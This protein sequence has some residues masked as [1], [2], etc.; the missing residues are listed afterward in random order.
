MMT[1]LNDIRT[2]ADAHSN[3]LHFVVPPEEI[4]VRGDKEKLLM[5]LANVLNNAVKFSSENGFI[6]LTHQIHEDEVWIQV[7]DQ[8]IGIPADKLKVIFEEF[9]QVEDHMTR[10]HG[11]LGLGLAISGA[12]I[13]ASSGRIWAESPGENQGTTVTISL[14]LV[15]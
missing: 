11:G 7:K 14:P 2:M 8:G 13:E 5:A 3:R 4:R 1:A 6:E 9:Y 10:R 15:K 12:I